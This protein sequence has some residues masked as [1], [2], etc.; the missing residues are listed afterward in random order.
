MPFH[1]TYVTDVEGNLDFFERFVELSPVLRYD[2]K[3]ELELVGGDSFFVFGGDAVDKGPGDIR[4]CR[5]LVSLKQRFPGRV[6]LLVGNRD[7]N[8]LRYTAELSEADMARPI[9]EIPRAH[10]DPK[11]TNLREHLEKV[12]AQTGVSVEAANTR[13]ERVKYMHQHTLGCAETF[14]FRRQE[15]ALLEG[16]PEATISDEEVVDN[17]IHDVASPEGALR[18]Y[19][20]HGS[21]GA[22]IGNTLFVHGAIDRITMGFVPAPRTPFENPS[23]KPPAGAFKED[24]GEWVEAMNAYLQEGL[25]DHAE[26][27][28]WDAERKS[29]GGEALMALQNRCAMWGRTVIS[30]CYSDGGIITNP[31][32]EKHRAAAW[33]AAE[34][35][36]LK[37]EAACSNPKDPEVAAWLLKNQIRRV[38][39]G[40]KPSGDSPA[41]LSAAYTGVEIVSGDTSFSDT[42]APDNRGIAVT[43]LD[44]SGESAVANHLEF[45]GIL[46]DGVMHRG[47]QHTLGGAEEGRGGDPLLGTETEDGWWYKTRIDDDGGF[48]GG[49]GGAA[50]LA[51]YRQC[52]GEGRTVEYRDVNVPGE[53]LAGE[54]VQGHQQ[55]REMASL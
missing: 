44:I 22:V 8:K 10:W 49:G 51:V 33:A 21:V 14:E 24:L 34:T 29:R 13:A 17:F 35:D 55:P 4:L 1:V 7:L 39:V 50:A 5:Q 9:D 43:S 52:K 3:G 6:F 27:P 46:R 2:E 19:L 32:A 37:F 36:A 23:E 11:A 16:R 26:R 20:E 42:R 18:Q 53:V 41:V 12:A 28:F 45:H 15:M 47:R 40:H 38:V 54:E 31:A 30:N 48:G 25:K